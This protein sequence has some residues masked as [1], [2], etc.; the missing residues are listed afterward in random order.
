MAPR[1]EPAASPFPPEVDEHLKKLMPPGMAPLLLFRVVAHNPRVLGRMRR[2]GLLDP[3]AITVRQREIVILRTTARCRSEYEWGVHVTFF[4]A[5][6]GL[7][8]AQIAATVTGAADDLAWSAEESMLVALADAL[9]DHATVDAALWSRLAATFDEAQLVELLFLAG[10]YHAVS[11]VT[12]A[13]EL[14]A[15]PGAARFPE[16]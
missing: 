4:A 12:N 15:E 11:F 8:E 16:G 5:A 14:P 10:L 1:I 9:H 7:S 3:G 6:A 13:T 2:G